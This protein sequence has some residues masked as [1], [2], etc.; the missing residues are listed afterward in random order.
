VQLAEYLQLARNPHTSK[1][2]IFYGAITGA[3]LGFL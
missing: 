3:S 1:L 2:T